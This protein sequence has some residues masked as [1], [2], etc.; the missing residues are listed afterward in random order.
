MVAT[1]RDVEEM[2]DMT[3][4]FWDEHYYSQYGDFSEQQTRMALHQ[5]IDGE[6]STAL[7]AKD[8]DRVIGY[9]VLIVAPVIWGN[10]RSA[11]EV[12]WRVEPEFRGQGVGKEL[13]NAGL[14]WAEIMDCD[15]LEAHDGDGKRLHLCVGSKPQL[16]LAAHS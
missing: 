11:A 10:V 16:E 3:R 14:E 9:I 7:V 8:E 13:L 6:L 4:D 1:H 15:L 12:L 2:I 5:M